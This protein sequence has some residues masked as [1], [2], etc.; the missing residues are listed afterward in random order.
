MKHL[1]T[2]L[3]LIVAVAPNTVADEAAP[4]MTPQQAH[5]RAL[6]AERSGDFV[7]SR[8]LAEFVLRAEPN[9]FATRDLVARLDLQEA[10]AKQRAPRAALD[11]VKVG[12]LKM[13]DVS[14]PDAI[15]YLRGV[16]RETG[17]NFV[18]IDPKREVRERVIPELSMN[19]ASAAVI[20]DYIA[21]MADL[22]LT[23][24]ERTVEIRAAAQ[25]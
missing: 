4:P 21:Q 7:T 18:L 10:R 16:T 13:V 2:A 12:E 14:V 24:T 25:P 1:L 22:R 6:A 23:Y 20:L 3:C 9:H 15:E 17:I 11:A 5:Q 8:Q 19:G